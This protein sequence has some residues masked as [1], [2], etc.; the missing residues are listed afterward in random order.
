MNR[1]FADARVAQPVTSPGWLIQECRGWTDVPPGGAPQN[2]HRA[3]DAGAQQ[4]ST[5]A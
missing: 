3:H 2:F 4:S 1:R 5:H